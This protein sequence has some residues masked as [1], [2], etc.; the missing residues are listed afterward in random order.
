MSAW[1]GFVAMLGV[2]IYAVIDRQIF[3]LLAE[4]I[5]RNMSLSDAQLGLLQGTGL[6]LAS[7][8]STPARSRIWAPS[9]SPT[10]RR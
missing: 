4:P 2:Y 8:R 1:L 6:A 5:R 7:W 3:I 10:T 9:S